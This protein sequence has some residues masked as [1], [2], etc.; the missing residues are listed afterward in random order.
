V[1]TTVTRVTDSDIDITSSKKFHGSDLREHQTRGT[2]PCKCLASYQR[3]KTEELLPV[4]RRYTVLWIQR[5]KWKSGKFK[6]FLAFALHGG[7][8]VVS[9]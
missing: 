2:Q 4:F 5:R 8:V 7:E 1:S 3:P 9:P 6:S